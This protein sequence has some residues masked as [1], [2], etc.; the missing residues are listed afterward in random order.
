MWKSFPV[1]IGPKRLDSGCK[2]GPTGPPPGPQSPGWV[3]LEHKPDVLK[4]SPV[5]ILDFLCYV[6]KFAK[7]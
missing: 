7:V 5:L 4:L 3:Q 1:W 6:L 2:L